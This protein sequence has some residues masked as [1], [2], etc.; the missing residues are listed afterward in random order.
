MIFH[1]FSAFSMLEFASQERGHPAMNIR[2]KI[3]QNTLNS[4]PRS[5][6]PIINMSDL[7]TRVAVCPDL[8][9]NCAF[10]IITTLEL[11][12][13]LCI[14]KLCLTT[15]KLIYLLRIF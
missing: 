1:S 14:L 10:T 2:V 11:E 9:V 8:I 7:F 3:L 12:V 4:F 5:F 6:P 13:F 15:L